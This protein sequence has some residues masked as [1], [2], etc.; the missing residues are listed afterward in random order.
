MKKVIL[1][2][3]SIIFIAPAFAEYKPIPKELSKQYKAEIEQIISEN[4][5]L[6]QK[7]INKIFSDA[8]E[9]YNKF[10]KDKESPQNAD[11]AHKLELLENRVDKPEFDLYKKLIDK[12]NQY[13]NIENDI[14]RTDWS[15]ELYDFLYPY[16]IDNKIKLHKINSITRNSGKKEKLIHKYYKKIYTYI[17]Y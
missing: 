8:K 15:G 2:I 9:I 1:I 13:T 4:Y 10:L 14:P 12:T 3:F 16:L 11:I 5:D 6:T 17:K 7:D